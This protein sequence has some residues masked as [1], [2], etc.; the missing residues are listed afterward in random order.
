MTT[1]HM[2]YCHGCNIPFRDR[3]T[4][5]EGWKEGDEIPESTTWHSTQREPEA[6]VFRHDN[7]ARVYRNR[8][9]V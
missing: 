8:E 4:L 6:F 1:T 5:P 2:D 9:V 7:S 3:V